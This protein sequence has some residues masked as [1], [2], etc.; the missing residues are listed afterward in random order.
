MTSRNVTNCLIASTFVTMATLGMV[1]Y[2]MIKKSD[3][4][5]DGDEIFSNS[6][7]IK[8]IR[9]INP[10][11]HDVVVTLQDIHAY[12]G[13]A[14]YTC[15]P[16]G[17]I[18]VIQTAHPANQIGFQ[19]TWYRLLLRSTIENTA[20]DIFSLE[21]DDYT[22]TLTEPGTYY[23]ESMVLSTVL[24][25]FTGPITACSFLDVNG[26][27]L[28]DILRRT[29]WQCENLAFRATAD[30]SPLMLLSGSDMFSITGESKV[31]LRFLFTSETET[32]VIITAARVKLTKI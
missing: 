23:V 8:I 4:L 6:S 16:A 22:I 31:F 3:F 11:I 28:Y 10:A 17:P 24:L 19:E 27:G 18:Q 5:S 20:T 13:F 32:D 7:R 25:N 26:I 21:S 15:L 14:N 30:F 2:L 9:N 1:I 29:A 12:F